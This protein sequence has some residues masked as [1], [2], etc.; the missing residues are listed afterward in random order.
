MAGKH[1]GAR[2]GAGRKPGSREAATKQEQ[3][4]ISEL[5]RKH[6]PDALAALVRI[7]KQGAS[8]SA[9]VAAANSILDRAY[10]KPVQAVEHA[11]KDGAP[12]PFD[13]WIIERAKPDPV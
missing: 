11:G 3:A 8:E 9:I 2:P 13:G 7:T 12:M 4:T 10:G 1:G 5:A 6:A